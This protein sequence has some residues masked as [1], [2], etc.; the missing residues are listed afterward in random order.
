MYINPLTGKPVVEKKSPSK[1]KASPPGSFF[2]LLSEQLLPAEEPQALSGPSALSPETPVAPELRLAGVS[3]SES[4][5]GLLE[6][7]S[8]ALGDLKF[9]SRDLLPLIEALEGDTTALLDIRAQ[10][11]PHDPLA[12]LIDRVA[13]VSAI[14]AE[15]FRRGDYR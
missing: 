5:I 9:S 4:A 10:L 14:E 6:S 13:T 7:F 15:K 1:T 12:R 3:T 11:P 8:Q 2:D